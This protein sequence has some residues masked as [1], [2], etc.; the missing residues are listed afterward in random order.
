M[1]NAVAAG[2]ARSPRNARSEGEVRSII[3]GWT[4]ALRARRLDAMKAYYAPAV[5]YYDALAPLQL[6]TSTYW[7]Y[8]EEY[9][10]MFPGAV[11]WEARG[12]KI[13][14]GDDVAF[15]HA[16]V[17]LAGIDANGKEQGAWMRSTIGYA[18]IDGK[19]LITHEHWSM[20]MDMETGK[21]RS[22]LEP[23]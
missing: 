5:V 13:H 15:S 21:T 11:K 12:L 3:D 20:P 1:T 18:K 8:W 19:W 7:K 6:D 22:D 16:L 9:F 23:A 14:A 17:Q 10:K 4:N 2:E